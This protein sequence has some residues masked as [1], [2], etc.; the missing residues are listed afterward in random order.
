[1]KK[2]DNGDK[3]KYLV[4]KDTHVGVIHAIKKVG[5]KSGGMRVVSYLID[6]GDDVRVDEYV[7]EAKKP[8]VF[9][10]QP[11]QLEITQ[12]NIVSLVE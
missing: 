4:G 8:N 11:R 5:L 10:R 2:Y 3:V 1:M 12:D 9:V 7:T 6:T